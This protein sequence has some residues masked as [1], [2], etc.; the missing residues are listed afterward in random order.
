MEPHELVAAEVRAELARKQL[1][2]VRAARALGWTQNYLS[3]RLRGMVAF[4]VTDLMKIAELL[5]V[6]VS[7]FFQFPAG[8]RRA[9]IRFLDHPDP[10]DHDDAPRCVHCCSPLCPEC[11]GC[12]CPDNRCHLLEPVNLYRSLLGLA[13]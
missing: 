1:S 7:T 11:G 3:V 6:P 13:A 9:P 2:G 10:D 12:W 4:D 5:E 8:V